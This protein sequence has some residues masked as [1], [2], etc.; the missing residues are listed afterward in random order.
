MVLN[1][2][3]NVISI[4]RFASLKAMLDWIAH[5]MLDIYLDTKNYSNLHHNEL[6]NYL[7]QW[8]KLPIDDRTTLSLGM[9]QL[10]ATSTWPRARGN[11][12]FT[13]HRSRNVPSQR[14]KFHPP[15]RNYHPAM[16]G[17]RSDYGLVVQHQSCSEFHQRAVDQTGQLQLT[18]L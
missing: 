5:H 12:E 9:V 6:I 2:K 15:I 14:P 18:G 11:V 1:W 16:F 7:F 13:L 17:N 4:S 8:R 10:F 3:K